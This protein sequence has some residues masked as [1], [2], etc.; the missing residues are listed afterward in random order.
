[1]GVLGDVLSNAGNII[2]KGRLGPGQMVCA[3]LADGTF[4][5]NAD[6]ARQVATAHPYGDWMKGSHRLEELQASVFL[7]APQ[8][9]AAETLRLQAANGARPLPWKPSP[10]PS[11]VT[12][13]GRLEC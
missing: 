8:L 12:A 6:I 1:M 7:D 2:R 13:T 11:V 5:E 4:L 9:S 10:C 3:N